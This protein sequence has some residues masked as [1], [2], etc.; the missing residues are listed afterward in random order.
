M[1]YDLALIV[2]RSAGVDRAVEFYADLAAEEPAQETPALR[3]A[4]HW[5]WQLATRPASA[6]ALDI[7]DLPGRGGP[8]IRWW[9]WRN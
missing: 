8:R 9:R 1:A 4:R 2:A 6:N 7:A 5:A 3:A